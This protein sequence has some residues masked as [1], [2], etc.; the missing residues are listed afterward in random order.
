MPFDPRANLQRKMEFF[1]IPIYFKVDLVFPESWL[2]CSVL[3]NNDIQ[4][5]L[6]K[7]FGGI[8]MPNLQKSGVVGSP[9]IRFA[10]AA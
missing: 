10:A 2:R 3:V 4:A 6:H 9:N 5:I 1:N 7:I 8:A